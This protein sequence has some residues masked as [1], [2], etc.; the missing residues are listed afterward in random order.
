MHGRLLLPAL[1]A[2]SLPLWMVPLPAVR[3][4]RSVALVTTMAAWAI[5]CALWLRVPYE[6]GVGPRGIADE[7][8]YYASLAGTSHPVTIRDFADHVYRN[9]GEVLRVIAQDPAAGEARSG[10]SSS[11]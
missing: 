1:F 4:T 9:Q 11:T 8:G 6:G 5:V 7:R 3:A 10:E 2:A